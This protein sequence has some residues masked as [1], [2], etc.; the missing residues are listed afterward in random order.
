LDPAAFVEGKPGGSLGS[1]VGGVD[2]FLFT[3]NN[4]PVESILHVGLLV[5]ALI[6]QLDVGLIL[7]EHQVGLDILARRANAGRGREKNISIP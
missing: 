2:G 3:I 7:S 1:G 4:I 5:L 6:K